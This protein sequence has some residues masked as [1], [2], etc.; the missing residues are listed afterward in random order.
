MARHAR[1]R[2]HDAAELKRASWCLRP[3]CRSARPAT[4]SSSSRTAWQRFR[5]FRSS[6]RSAV[7]RH[8]VG[9]ERRRNRRHRRPVAVVRRHARQPAPAE[10]RRQLIHEYFRD[11]YPPP[12]ADDADDGV[13]DRFRRFAYR[14][15]PVAALPAVDFPTIQITATLPGAS[16]ET[17]AASVASPIERQLSTISGIS[18]M[19]VVVLAGH[20]ADHDPVR[21]RPQ[22]RRRRRSTCRPRLRPRSAGCRSK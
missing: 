1:H 5:T 8:R 19:N 4:L 18:S 13:A 17:M 6:G 15:L 12:G 3:P 11:L 14:L 20:D 22:Y 10:S 21:S 2:R 7:R 9:S 16:P